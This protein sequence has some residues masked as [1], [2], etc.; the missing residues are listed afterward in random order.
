MI[1]FSMFL[2][3]ERAN[4]ALLG[5]P[6]QQRV[7]HCRVLQVPLDG[8]RLGQLHA[9]CKTPATRIRNIVLSCP[10]WMMTPVMLEQPLGRGEPL[11]VLWALFTLIRPG[12]Q[13]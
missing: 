3:W 11:C 1:N 10:M 2:R 12:M 6:A 4:L 9:T 7:T 8:S 5:Q 13:L